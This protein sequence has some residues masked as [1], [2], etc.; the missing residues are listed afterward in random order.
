VNSIFDLFPARVVVCPEAAL[1][2]AESQSTFSWAEAIHVQHSR[3]V[4]AVRVVLTLDTVMIAADSNSGP[5]LIFREK[6]D[7]A[8]LNKTKKRATLTTVTGKFLSVEKDENCGCG[9]RLRTWNPSR[10]MYSSKDPVE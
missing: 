6:Y 7:P 3:R 2:S 9:S 4:E 10:T 5:V 1:V 8:T